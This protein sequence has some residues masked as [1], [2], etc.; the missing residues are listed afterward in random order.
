MLQDERLK[1]PYKLDSLVLTPPY[2]DISID[3]LTIK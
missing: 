3:S 1:I 2:L